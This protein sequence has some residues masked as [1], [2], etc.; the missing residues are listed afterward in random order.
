MPKALDIRVK[1]QGFA[2]F[3]SGKTD[4]RREKDTFWNEFF[5]IFGIDR[6]RHINFEYP[7][8]DPLDNT[9]FVDVFWRKIFLGEHKSAAKNLDK[10]KEQAE[11]YLN[12]IERTAPHDLPEFYAVCDF[13]RFHLYRRIPV[14]GGE[15]EWKF[16]LHEL[17]SYIERG[18]FDFMYGIGGSIRRIQEEASIRAAEAVGR[19]HD[20]LKSEGIYEEHELRLLITRLLFLFFADDSAVFRRNFLFQDFLERHRAEELG[21]KL[22][23]LFEFLDTPEHRRS[24]RRAEQFD[25]FEYVNG[26]LFAERL[27]DFEFNGKQRQILLSCCGL[28]WSG[29]SPEIFGTLFQSVMNA[30]ERREAGAHYTESANIEK[31][32]DSLFLDRLYAEFEAVKSRKGRE[33]TQKLA[34]LYQKIR[35]LHFLDPACGCGNFLIV[36]Y[37]RL[38]ALEDDIIAEAMNGGGSEALFD[39]P[40]VQCRL[41][42]FYGIEQDEFAVL[43]ARTAM[44]LKN[45]Q[46]NLRTLVRF[47][48]RVACDTLPLTDSAEIIHANALRIEWPQADYIFGN[49]PFIGHAW[50]SREQQEDCAL[51][52]PPE[53]KFGKM[54]YVANWYVRAARIMQRQPQV[55]TAFVSTNSICQGE[56]AGIL[57]KWLFDAGFE[58]SFAHRTFRWTSQASGKAAVHCI[59]VGFCTKG[60]A[61]EKYLFDYPDIQGLP[62][63]KRAAN[64]N[65]YLADG[66]SVIVASRSKPP[67]GFVKMTNGSKFVDGG[68]WILSPEEKERLAT[69]YPVL[70]PYIK[71]LIGAEE[72][73]K[74]KQRYCLW[75]ADA[76]PSELAEIGKIAEIRQRKEAVRA[77]RLK[78]PTPLFRKSAE[79]PY[80]VTEN[81]QPVS[82]FLVMPR[83]TSENRHYIPIDFLSPESVISDA[84]CSIADA[85][86]Y[87]FGILCST[88]HM[89][90]VRTVAG[91]L[92]SDYRYDANVYH[93]FPF[94]AADEAQ[95]RAVAEAARAVLDARKQERAADPKTSLAVLY[96]PDTMPKS[97]RRAHQ[98]LDKAVDQAYGR[99]FGSEAD[100][101]GFLFDLYR[102]RQEEAA[103]AAKPRKSRKKQQTDGADGIAGKDEQ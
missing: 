1:A 50:R 81:R 36:A 84:V 44:W 53:G 40:A 95:S 51:N 38:R 24:K 46:C 22:G 82:D 35:Q 28:D 48:G 83:V 29:I 66:A 26:G 79:T 98:Q 42:Q 86:E 70:R 94:P 71:P 69:Q 58:I 20:A 3:W 45:H 27:R 56:Q 63:K 34:A 32:I 25:G 96:N 78:S 87:L 23:S 33:K 67:A 12:E 21:E 11:R 72:L 75:F 41:H 89:A 15:N 88:M 77:Q 55:Q 68:N 99:T 74:G 103:A 9:Q 19:L 37:D 59:I 92:K 49:P 16:P 102:R 10:A 57:W 60:Q 90:W 54:D 4:E 91:R 64:I 47:E 52:F 17:P 65:Q 39:A 93:S 6:K 30:E 85:R 13:G 61:A 101:I 2:E 62:Q 18:V 73:I 5:A 14:E 100:R 43:I 31:V 80:L 76:K 8:K 7:V 97:L